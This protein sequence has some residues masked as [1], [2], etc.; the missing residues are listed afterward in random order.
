M[1]DGVDW[2]RVPDA[3]RP[4]RIIPVSAPDEVD[5]FRFARVDD[6][7]EADGMPHYTPERGDV[8]DAGERERLLAFL[9]GGTLVLETDWADADRIDPTRQ[10]AVRREYRSDGTW[11]WNFAV[12]YYLRRHNVAPEPEFRRWIVDH[13]YRAAVAQPDVAARALAATNHRLEI[14]TQRYAE[15]KAEHPEP[16]PDAEVSPEVRESLLRL[17]WHLGRDV[18][19]Q[20]DEFLAERMDELA[21]MPFERDGYPPYVPIAAARSVL[22]EFGGLSSV[23]NGPG[24]TAAQVPFSIFPDG[25]DDDLMNFVIQVQMLGETIGEPVFQVGEVE[26]GIGALVIDGRGRVFVCGPVDLYIAENIYEAVDHLLRGIRAQELHE[27][28]L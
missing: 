3:K 14:L 12:E 5:G 4:T 20:V 22:D 23:L 15:Y 10:F 26:R 8:T 13:G 6:G 16:G 11:V 28:G 19:E 1:T 25:R 9:T 27:V 24:R 2:Q 18:S 7:V 21:E 17:G